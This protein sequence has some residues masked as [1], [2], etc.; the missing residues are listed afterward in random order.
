[1]LSFASVLEELWGSTLIAVGGRQMDAASLPGFT[2]HDGELL[3]LASYQ[4]AAGHCELVT[5]NSLRPGGGIGSALLAAV[6]QAAREAG[7]LVLKLV[8]TNDNLPALRFY[9]RR[10]YRLVALRPGAVDEAR[11]RKPQIP[12]VGLDGIPLHDELELLKGL[13]AQS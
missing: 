4:L 13:Q 8:T 2:C 6:E 9:Q 7:C 1:M 5:L 11:L 3:G 10:G 12:Q